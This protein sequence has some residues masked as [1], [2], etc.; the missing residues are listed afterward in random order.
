M[1]LILPVL[2]LSYKPHSAIKL[3]SSSVLFGQ[4]EHH[5]YECGITGRLLRPTN[6]NL[7]TL[8][9]KYLQT[10]NLFIRFTAATFR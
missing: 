9:A 5:H 4:N 8:A 2:R 10:E 6:F 1:Y 3:K 7:E